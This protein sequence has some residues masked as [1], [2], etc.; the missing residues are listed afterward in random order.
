MS[1][2]DKHAPYWTWA[3][4]YEP[5]HHLYCD[6]Y[7]RRSWQKSGRYVPCNLPERPVCHG[8]GRTRAYVPLCTWE[9]VYPTWREA[10]WL[11]WKA[12]TPR[13][14]VKHVGHDPERVRE[15]DKLGKMVKEYNA[16]GELDDGDFPCWQARHAARWLWD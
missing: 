14:F 10:R 4:W 13:W 6:S 16:T 2:T 8:G 3:T 11:T 1:R 15:R 9:P 5:S 7:V 12:P